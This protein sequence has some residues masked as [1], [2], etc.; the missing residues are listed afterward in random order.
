MAGVNI[1]E[2]KRELGQACVAGDADKVRSLLSKEDIDENTRKSG[3]QFAI[4]K[5]TS[6]KSGKHPIARLLLTEF[7]AGELLSDEAFRSVLL[8]LVDTNDDE[9]LGILRLVL[10]RGYRSS[11]NEKDK[12]E[13][14][15]HRTP[16]LVAALHPWTESLQIL[17]DS[18]ADL[19][20]QFKNGE[21]IL[22]HIAAEKGPEE[23]NALDVVKRMVS[24]VA[25]PYQPEPGKKNALHWAASTG[26]V[27]MVRILLKARPD[28][29]Y[30]QTTSERGRTALHYAAAG[31][32]GD[33]TVV[34]L[35]LSAGARHDTQS[36]GHWTPLHNAAQ[37]GNLKAVERLL[38]AGAD[39]NALL[40][41]RVTPLHWAAANG[42]EEIVKCFLARKEVSR[43]KRDTLWVTPMIWAASNGHKKIAKLFHP[44][45]DA[46]F[47]SFEQNSACRA[48]SFRAAIVDFERTRGQGPPESL[49][50]RV[51]MWEVLYK[52][53]FAI[54]ANPYPSES[55]QRKMAT[56]KEK[57]MKQKTPQAEMTN[58]QSEKSSPEN[59][60][61]SPKKGLEE[62][63]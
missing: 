15:L 50:K 2:W 25:N 48:G 52:E 33:D 34:D 56:G 24:R 26:K 57:K 8:Q 9:L 22:S 46:P 16:L 51:N 60:H 53:D 45:H 17:L 55:K 18:G 59:E 38:T 39:P 13:Q 21:T 20:T 23:E 12:T 11:L 30:V 19:N 41:S 28:V 7:N 35:L 62:E 58:A 49:V 5:A 10:R 4:Q 61:K 6:R 31:D 40:S 36:D 32:C 43:H 3:I 44:C 27:E 47:L 42:H 37:H 14:A 1:A 63:I 54:S 29:E